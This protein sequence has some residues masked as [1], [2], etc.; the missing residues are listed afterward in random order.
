MDGVRGVSAPEWVGM[1][2]HLIIGPTRGNVGEISLNTEVAPRYVHGAIYRLHHDTARVTLCTFSPV[3][4]RATLDAWRDIS[5]YVEKRA[6]L[7]R[8]FLRGDTCD[9]RL[10][11][12][13]DPDWLCAFALEDLYLH[14]EFDRWLP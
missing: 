8:I 9:E 7:S 2:D 5:P 10:D 4:M 3:A 11:R 6:A 12:V 14:G 1:I 13:K